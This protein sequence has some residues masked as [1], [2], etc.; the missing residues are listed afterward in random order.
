MNI[1]V[2]SFGFGNG[3]IEHANYVFDVRC[4]QNPFWVE[5]LRN[6]RG[7]DAEVADYIFSFEESRAFFEQALSLVQAAA[8]LFAQKQKEELV[9]AFGCTGGHHRSVACAERMARALSKQYDVQVY[10]RDI[11]KGD[12]PI[13]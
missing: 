4:L 9:V 11:Q 10:H 3:M 12:P 8:S 7:T 1:K 13:V 6:K 5:S 2:M